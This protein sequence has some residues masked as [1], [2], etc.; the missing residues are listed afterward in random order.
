[1]AKNPRRLSPGE[2]RARLA[3]LGIDDAQ[4]FAF[5]FEDERARLAYDFH[6]HR[7]HQLL[8]ATSGVVRLEAR[9]QS[10]LLPPQRA[11]WIPAGVAHATD[12]NGASVLSIYFEQAPKL[13]TDAVHVFNAPPVVREMVLY[14]RRW[15]MRTRSARDAE[16]D[17]F[18]RALL[19]VV[20]SAVGAGGGYALPRPRSELTA[21]AIQA[22]LADLPRATLTRAARRAGTT[23]RTLRRHLVAE[24]GLSF[25]AF[26]H[27]ARVQR[28]LEL[29]VASERSVLAVALEVG[30][31]SQSAFTQAFRRST[32]QTP[33]AFRAANLAGR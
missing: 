20:R 30:F 28:A 21:R 7:R 14:A 16:A 31:Q 27:Q 15:P 33:R 25:R 19:G 12:L 24:T 23:A 5:A 13:P 29:L 1:M 9:T 26:L 10:F 18:F 4:G 22:V 8:Y 2:T 11:A 17:V 32:G 6:A 3:S